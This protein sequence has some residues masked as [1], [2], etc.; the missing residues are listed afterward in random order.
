MGESADP[1]VEATQSKEGKAE[2]Q[3]QRD[4]EQEAV[5]QEAIP[6]TQPVTF[7]ASKV[8]E[9]KPV[10]LTVGETCLTKT[11]ARQFCPQVA[12]TTPLYTPLRSNKLTE[13]CWTLVHRSSS[14]LLPLES[15]C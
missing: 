6:E 1:H 7:N 14:C 4:S 15:A 3:R 11:C 2:T 5:K 10:P 8:T 9:K 12:L 13:S